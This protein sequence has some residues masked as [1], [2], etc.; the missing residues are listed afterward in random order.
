MKDAWRAVGDVK[1]YALLKPFNM[2][3]T[4]EIRK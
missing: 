1:A 3:E 4:L 2:Q